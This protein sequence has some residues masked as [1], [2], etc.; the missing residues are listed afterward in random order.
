M[1]ITTFNPM[2][3][4]REA[5]AI[6]G[7]FEALGFEKRHSKDVE[8]ND[9]DI[10][11]VRMKDAN[12]FHVDVAQ[13]PVPRD[14]MAIRINVDDFDAA[15]DILTRHGL[16]NINAGQ[17]VETG[18]SRSEYFAAPSGFTIDLVKHVRK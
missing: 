5:E 18:S 15:K 10:T 11:S 6:I 4:S 1:K 7:L 17:T 9:T 14:M 13:V 12:G 8:A 2:I 16:V 3:I